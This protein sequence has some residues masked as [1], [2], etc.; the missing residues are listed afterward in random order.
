MAFRRLRTALGLSGTGHWTTLPALT[1]MGFA[2]AADASFAGRARAVEIVLVL[3][4]L[5]V[6]LLPGA[7]AALAA[8]LD[9]R[10]TLLVADA[11]RAVLV[12]SVPM[13]DLLIPSLRPLIWTSVATVLVSFLGVLW[14][15]A[16]SSSTRALA[17]PVS[18]DPSRQHAEA[19]GRP[20]H[21][22]GGSHAGGGSRA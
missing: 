5:P 18:D 22:A 10:S 2:T 11:L 16:A 7:A 6:L 17:W 13:A 20:S 15:A 14:G 21:A 8:R 9:R 12:L 3:W 19:G 1:A 4:L